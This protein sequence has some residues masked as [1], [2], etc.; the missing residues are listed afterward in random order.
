MKDIFILLKTGDIVYEKLIFPRILKLLL[1][2][3][4]LLFVLKIV[5]FGLTYLFESL[6]LMDGSNNQRISKIRY[7]SYWSRVFFVAMVIPIIEETLFRLNLRYSRLNFAIFIGGVVYYL[8]NFLS[9]LERFHAISLGL[10]AGAMV[11]LLIK[12]NINQIL[13]DFWKVHTKK[14]FYLFLSIF[15]L[16]HITNY[17][18]TSSL[19]FI[20]PILVLPHFVGGIFYS[21]ARLKAGILFAICLHA[22]NN[23]IPFIAMYFSN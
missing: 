3:L 17:E 15:T 4:V 9:D 7:S 14:I 20:S 1:K 5:A 11:W 19:F 16:I 10:L 13:C 23:A 6:G 8:F 21:Y 22:I 18:M 2:I 12:P